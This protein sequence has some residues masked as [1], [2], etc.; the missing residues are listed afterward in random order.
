MFP[1]HLSTTFGNNSDCL[2][3]QEPLTSN[4][5]VMKTK[6]NDFLHG[7]CTLC[8]INSIKYQTKLELDI[9]CL[10]AACVVYETSNHN[11]W[12]VVWGVIN[13]QVYKTNTEIGRLKETPLIVAVEGLPYGWSKTSDTSFQHKVIMIPKDARIRDQNY[14]HDTANHANPDIL[15]ELK[16]VSSLLD[17]PGFCLHMPHPVMFAPAH[18]RDDAN[19]PISYLPAYTPTRYH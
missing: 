9:V 1:D 2:I 17:N 16:R 5:I 6:C 18:T 3:C 11:H 13:S 7:P 14:K 19:F 4:Q 12:V 10:C 8:Y 15:S